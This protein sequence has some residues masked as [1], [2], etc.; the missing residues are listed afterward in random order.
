[1]KMLA[2]KIYLQDTKSTEQQ[3]HKDLNCDTASSDTF[4]H[5]PFLLNDR[6]ILYNPST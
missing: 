6:G 4:P 3:R 5:K 1:M 2:T